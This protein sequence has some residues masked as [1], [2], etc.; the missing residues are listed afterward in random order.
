MKTFTVLQ[1][2]NIAPQPD[3]LDKPTRK[4]TDSLIGT[5]PIYELSVNDARKLLLGIQSD[6]SYKSTV[7][8]YNGVVPENFSDGFP[9]LGP[10]HFKIFL[11]KNKTGKF[12]IIIYCHGGGWVL[13]SDQTHGR[14]M[15][16]LSNKLNAAVIYVA[17]SLAPEHKFPIQILQVKQVMLY[18]YQYGAT[19]DL[20]K[21]IKL[22]PSNLIIMGDSAGGDMATV[23]SLLV[24][25]LP[26]PPVKIKAQ[27]LLYP[28]TELSMDTESYKTY[29]NGPWLSK[30]SS[31]WFFNAYL[32][33]DQ[34]RNL[35]LASPLLAPLNKLAKMPPTLIIFG[36]NDPL[37]S[38]ARLYAH[39][40][41]DAGVNVIATEFL[42]T[43]HDFLMLDPLKN[44]PA[45]EGAM[46]LIVAYIDR[47]FKGQI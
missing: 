7:D 14:L 23:V 20:G 3:L 19:F 21:N 44:S 4:F 10:V 40:L 28:V 36:E 25:D 6:T 29:I 12:P 27:V 24:N 45:V 2:D 1:S 32:N 47:V 30:K 9:G 11:P 17:Y 22:D 13:G 31:E 8:I 26:E 5:T 15:A 38:D 35:A 42:G 16:N 33:D 37:N 39:K 41:M 18:T 46:M 43:I 34:H